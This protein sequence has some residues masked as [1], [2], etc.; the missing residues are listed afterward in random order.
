LTAKR[1]SP[2][3]RLWSTFIL[4]VGTCW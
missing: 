1:R 3:H 4:V 2:I